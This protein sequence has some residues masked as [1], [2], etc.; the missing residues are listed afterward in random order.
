MASYLHKQAAA[1]TAGLSDPDLVDEVVPFEAA[2]VQPVD[3]RSAWDEALAVVEFF[4]T[5]AAEKTWSAPP[6]WPGLVQAQEPA[7]ALAFCLGNFPQLVRSFQP[8]LQS[9][10]L[11]SMRPAEGR[12]VSASALLAWTDQIVEKKQYPQTLLALGALRLARQ[13]DRAAELIQNHRANVPSEWRALWAN[14]E[15]ALSWHR[16]RANEAVSLWEGQGD[17]VP[18][19]FNRG[20]AALFMNQPAK[21]RTGLTAAIKKLP[22]TSAW[23]HL[24]RL[25]LTL[26]E[27]RS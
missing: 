7:L 5:Q 23:H 3:P 9:N 22:E 16:G 12:P 14:E 2:P 19:L 10:D 20:M 15:A 17:S 8:L 11:T 1:L 24:G 6:D 27:T 4:H 21:A 13:F 26:T 25:Y 18:V